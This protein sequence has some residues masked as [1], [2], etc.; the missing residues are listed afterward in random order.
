[1]HGLVNALSCLSPAKIAQ[2]LKGKRSFRL[3][4]V[5]PELKK[6]CWSSHLREQRY[7]SCTVA[8]CTVDAMTEKMVERYVGNQDDSPQGFKVWDEESAAPQAEP[9]FRPIVKPPSSD[10]GR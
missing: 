8:S 10:E 5:F 6:G 3:L 4:R 9:A 1:M 2:Y 7:F